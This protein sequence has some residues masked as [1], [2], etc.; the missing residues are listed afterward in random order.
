MKNIHYLQAELYSLITQDMTIF[1]FVDAHS[2]DGLWF[3]DL[4][5]PGEEWINHGFWDILGRGKVQLPPGPSSWQDIIYPEDL[6]LAQENAK[7]HLADPS[8]PYDLVLRFL[9]DDGTTR[10]VRTRGLAIRDRTGKAVRMLRTHKDISPEMTDR[11]VTGNRS[12][13]NLFSRAGDIILVLDRQLS[14]KGYFSKDDN[15]LIVDFRHGIPLT[16]QGF[17]GKEKDRLVHAVQL[18][19]ATGKG[20]KL[21]FSIEGGGS[22]KW[23]EM[24]ISAIKD[25]KGALQEIICLANRITYSMV[26]IQEGAMR[27]PPGQIS[28]HPSDLLIS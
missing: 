3:W 11:A 10:W 13:S 18:V 2:V 19:S 9:H 22:I 5:N 6:V 27:Y 4:V 7:R 23:Y 26:D 12:L 24:V 25:G 17:A 14:I 16:G 1:D 28:A 20:R 15:W 8:V 21:I